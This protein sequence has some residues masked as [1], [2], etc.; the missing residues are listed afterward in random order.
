VTRRI[1]RLRR[2]NAVNSRL[3]GLLL[4]IWIAFAL[5]ICGT[6]PRAQSHLYLL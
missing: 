1:K 3:L 6:V 2:R 5:A 4:G